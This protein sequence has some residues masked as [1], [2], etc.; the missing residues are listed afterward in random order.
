[1]AKEIG[2]G[3]IGYAFM[4]KAHSNGWRQVARFFDVPYTPVLKTICGRN[5]QAVAAAAKQFGW[6][7]AQT[8]WKKVIK[9][10]DIQIID[11]CTPGNEHRPM[12]IAALHAGKHVVCEKP[13]ANNLAEARE[14]VAAAKK[15]GTR[16]LTAFNYR[17]VP[18]IALAKKMIEEG[19]IGEIYHW[20]A[21]YLQDWIMD[22]N[23]P[24]VWRLRKEVAGSGPHGDLNA[25]ITDLARHL[26]GEISEVVGMKKTFIEERPI[27]EAVSGGLGAKAG[28]RKGKVTVED[29]FLFLARF[30]N[31]ALG[32]FE[33]TR[34]AGGRKNYN[35]FEINGSK[36][37]IVFNLERLNEL[38]YCDLTEKDGR[39][40]GFRTIMCNEASQ[41]Y[42]EAWWPSGH[43]IGWEHTF[44][45]EF[46]D[47]LEAIRRG[48]DTQPNFEDGMKTQAVLEAGMVS[49]EKGTW[50]K[51]ASL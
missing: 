1:M 49:A 41:P 47:F 19:K 35:S 38:Q 37:S 2:V 23:F 45:H 7:K 26:V 10:P 8:D 32:S 12:A 21:V 9:D 24:L 50:V 15:S 25:H 20:R 5:K 16:T 48:R 46:K 6:Q 3:M 42:N 28:R 29:A 43:I 39:F 34:F 22:P 30:D 17:R 44:T 11:I 36:G 33:A 4:G 18:A 31:G 14:M 13:L 27:Q 51:V 40:K